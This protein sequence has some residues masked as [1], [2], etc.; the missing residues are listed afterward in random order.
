MRYE[1]QSHELSIRGGAR[2]VERFH[3]E[4]ER[5]FGFADRTRPVQVVTVEVR[6]S[7]PMEK[8]TETRTER[9]RPRRIGR[10]EVRDSGRFMSAMVRDREGLSPGFGLRGPAL[11][12][13]SGATLWIPPGWNGR[14]HESG[15]FVLKKG[16]S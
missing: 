16:R 4:H 3:E 12:L 5:R 8:M 13:E 14:V 2:L 1:G 11:V 10:Q 15:T 7:L 9:T 6:A